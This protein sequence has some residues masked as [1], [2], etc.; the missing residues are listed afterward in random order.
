MES[1]DYDLGI[2]YMD[3]ARFDQASLS[4]PETD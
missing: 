1:S 2:R 3:I 4:G